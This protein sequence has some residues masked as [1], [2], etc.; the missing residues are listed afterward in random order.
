LAGRQHGRVTPVRV[1]SL[2]VVPFG[3]LS[4][5]EP[6]T[7]APSTTSTN[8]TVVSPVQVALIEPMNFDTKTCPAWL[9]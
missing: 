3:T 6:G 5:N 7:R 9:W 4:T 8:L 2:T 1:T